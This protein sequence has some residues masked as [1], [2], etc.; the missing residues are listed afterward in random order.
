MIFPHGQRRSRGPLA[1]ALLFSF[2]LCL[3]GCRRAPAGPDPGAIREPSVLFVG[4]DGADW[5][6]LEPLMAQGS[7]PNLARLERSGSGGTLLT[8]QP[9]LSPLVWTTMMTGRSPL[10]HRILDFV[11]FDRA[12]GRREPIT[13]DERQVPAVWNLAGSADRDVAI[14]GLWATF[15]AES[16]RGLLVSDRFIA[17]RDSIPG[18]VF[19]PG[20]SAWAEGV[21][22]TARASVDL[23][24]LATVLPD[25]SPAEW[26]AAG[27]SQDPFA[28]PVSGLRQVL[29]QTEIV[30]RMATEWLA[31]HR[32]RLSVVYFEGTDTIGHLF[33][34]F[35]PPALASVP[36]GE[37]ARF[38][39]VPERYFARV[40]AMLG[41]FAQIAERTGAVLMIASDHGFEWGADRPTTLSS[42]ASATAAQWHRKEGIYLLVGPGIPAAPGHRGR[43]D[44]AQV[45]ASLLALSGAPVRD[46]MAPA[47]EEVAAAGTATPPGV[48]EDRQSAS[49]V[50]E[51]AEAAEGAPAPLAGAKDRKR[52]AADAVG[53][54]E[55][56]KLHSLGYIGAT[57][58]TPGV[59]R[60][61][62]TRTAASF[63]N[64]AQILEL[65]SRTDAAVAAYQ[66]AIEQE[67]DAVAPK[68]NLSNLLFEN[69]R[70][71]ATSDRLLLEAL[72]G[73]AEQGPR[74]VLERAAAWRQQ[75]RG[76]RAISLLDGA[77][78]TLPENLELTLFRGKGRIEQGDCRG[79]RTDFATAVA[80]DESR[81]GSWAALATAHLCLGERLATRR[82]FERA[83]ALAPERVELQRALAALSSAAGP[84]RD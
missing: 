27:E 44:V 46:G 5:R 3:A 11:H 19:P 37:S 70:D 68:W 14:F 51:R 74:M 47:L 57:L 53:E 23:P 58:A 28:A 4:L 29:T 76:D 65:A 35:V 72:R 79:A 81:A 31:A 77:V 63:S 32:P 66:Q 62:G 56:K 75:G 9:P 55:L 73:G 36:A 8:Q 48:A 15:P 43:G 83:V 20:E 18:A 38:R 2:L 82:A 41:E 12:T 54:E 84:A 22:R 78:A 40:D 71:A 25:V 24:T 7:L 21:R 10:E 64:E 17:A 61:H 33:A 59:P 26:S 30:R 16:V 69:G 39:D 45:A 42:V 50:S 13:S 67:P 80:L 49:N 1:G 60:P 34:P 6:F 52:R